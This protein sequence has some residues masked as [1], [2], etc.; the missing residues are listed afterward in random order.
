MSRHRCDH[1]ARTYQCALATAA[2]AEILPDLVIHSDKLNK[3]DVYRTYVILPKSH[4]SRSCECGIV[5]DAYQRGG[6]R[7]LPASSSNLG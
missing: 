2:A 3:V 7:M 5:C 1:D 4:F 6:A